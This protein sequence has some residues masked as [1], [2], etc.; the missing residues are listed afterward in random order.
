MQSTLV[1]LR[2]TKY[3][4]FLLL[5]SSMTFEFIEKYHIYVLTIKLYSAQ[6][7]VLYHVLDTVQ[8][9]IIYRDNPITG[10]SDLRHSLR[11]NAEVMARAWQIWGSLVVG[12][13]KCYRLLFF[14]I[15]LVRN[16][17]QKWKIFP[18]SIQLWLCIMYCTDRL[19]L[20][21]V[22]LFDRFLEVKLEQL[23]AR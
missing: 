6:S 3:W 15:C 9:N 16:L 19:T 21:Y 18:K 22:R 12:V 4:P 5:Q 8:Y 13:K 14:F 2:N 17:Q 10:W 1:H 23:E 20:G 7:S 11:L